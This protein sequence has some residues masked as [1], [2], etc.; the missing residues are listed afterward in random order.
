MGDARRRSLTGR[1][2]GV[3]PCR[4]PGAGGGRPLTADASG[5]VGFDRDTKLGEESF[6]DCSLP[7]VHGVRGRVCGQGRAGGVK[8][9]GPQVGWGA[10][11][12]CGER[13]VQNRTEL[14]EEQS[15]RLREGLREAVFH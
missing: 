1:V 14:G 7:Q 15:W 6:S 10:A 13:C 3:V 2:G 9:S 12:R 4:G 11:G 5:G 8:A